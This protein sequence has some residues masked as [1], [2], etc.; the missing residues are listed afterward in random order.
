[1][2]LKFRRNFKLLVD[3]QN[4]SLNAA[5][6]A[7]NLGSTLQQISSLEIT[8]P[9]TIEFDVVRQNLASVNTAFITVY[10]LGLNTRTLIRKDI[11]ETDI[12]RPIELWAGYG[13]GQP[14]VLESINNPNAASDARQTFPRIFQGNVTRAYSYRQGVNFLTR[15]ECQDA[16]FAAVNADVNFSYAAGTPILQIIEDLINAMPNVTIGAIGDFPGTL[17][18]GISVIGDP[19]ERL[20]EI[21]GGRFFIDNERGYTLQDNEYLD[22]GAVPLITD[23]NGIIGVPQ[24]ELTLVKLDLIFEPGISVYQKIQLRTSTVPYYNGFYIVKGVSHKG[25][26][27]Q[28]VC[29]AVVT[30]L[31][32]DNLDPAAKLVSQR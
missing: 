17:A 4:A 29:G 20:L 28:S 11:W 22:S 21:S 24:K 26:I 18:R 25:M 2:P 12:Y 9:F 7:S 32:L 31:I 3:T 30:S 23:D 5:V 10:N 15:L 13:D 14:P 8:P 19:K 1:M 27:S 16:G 6:G